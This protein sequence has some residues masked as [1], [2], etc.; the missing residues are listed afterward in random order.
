[1][2]AV[3]QALMILAGLLMGTL[4]GLLLNRLVLP[5]LPLSLGGRPPIPPLLPLTSW[6]SLFQFYLFLVLAFSLVL[7]S[8]TVML[9]RARL[10]R[11]LRIGQE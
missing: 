7:G 9:W 11:L 10:Q 3:E 1:M 8:A 6:G 4:L 2:L 5:G